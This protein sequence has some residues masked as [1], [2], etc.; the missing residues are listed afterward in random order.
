MWY[1]KRYGHTQIK[2]NKIS[3]DRMHNAELTRMITDNN[4]RKKSWSALMPPYYGTS[5][6]PVKEMRGN[7]N[8]RTN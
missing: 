7:Y 6:S 8:D 1:T 4:G 3:K 5:L 2:V